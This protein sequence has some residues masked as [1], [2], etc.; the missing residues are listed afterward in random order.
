MLFCLL[1]SQR[2]KG[3]R[4]VFF[5]TIIFLYWP[6]RQQKSFSFFIKDNKANFPLAQYEPKKHQSVNIRHLE[7]SICLA[8][9]ILLQTKLLYYIRKYFCT[10]F[11][12][13][14]E[15]PNI[16][17]SEIGKKTQIGSD[18]LPFPLIGNKNNCINKSFHYI[19]L[20]PHYYYNK[21]KKIL[22]VKIQ[23]I[24]NN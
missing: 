13:G 7:F 2:K 22:G 6:K 17:F 12:V 19:R 3:E 5:A 23:N 10:I 9:S 8:M 4:V 24:I 16:F 11:K 20:E 1:L 21:K 18:E 15:L 14:I